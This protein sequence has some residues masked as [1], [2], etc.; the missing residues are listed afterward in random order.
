MNWAKSSGIGLTWTALYLGWH[1]V[2]LFIAYNNP[3]FHVL[4]IESGFGTLYERATAVNIDFWEAMNY[5]TKAFEDAVSVST[6]RFVL[7]GV[8]YG[9]SLWF[10]DDFRKALKATA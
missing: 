2:I 3:A 8:A 6:W 9:A 5:L 7:T 1:G 10:L 4:V